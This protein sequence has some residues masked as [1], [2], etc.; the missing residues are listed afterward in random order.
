MSPFKME[1]NGVGISNR[2]GRR[3]LSDERV[4]FEYEF[5]TNIIDSV[6]SSKN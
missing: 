6:S 5:K 4:N 1:E 3:P 2:P